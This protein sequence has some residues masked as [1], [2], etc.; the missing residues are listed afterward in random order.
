MLPANC[1]Y[2]GYGLFVGQGE[3]SIMNNIKIIGAGAGTGKTFRLSQEVSDAVLKRGVRPANIIITTFTRKAASEL[4]SRVGQMLIKN[5]RPA[6][7][8]PA[9]SGPYR[10]SEWGM[11]QPAG[12]F[13]VPCRTCGTAEGHYRGR[14]ETVFFPGNVRDNHARTRH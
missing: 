14:R 10:Y 8:K 3:R 7:S 12:A 5:P 6:G 13:C 1:T 2:C 9:S 4:L 11:R